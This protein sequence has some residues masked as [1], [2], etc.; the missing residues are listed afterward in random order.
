MRKLAIIVSESYNCLRGQANAE[1][2]RIKYLKQIADYQIDVFSFSVYEGWLV[3]KLRGTEYVA[4]PKEKTIDGIKIRYR[5]QS[6]S[7]I[8]YLLEVKFHLRPIVNKNWSLKF[9]DLFKDYD[10]IMAHSDDCG[11][12]ALSVHEKYGIPYCITWHGSDIHTSPFTSQYNFQ[13]T[14]KILD[15]ATKNFMVSNMLLKTA[16]RISS[17]GNKIVLYNGI[18]SDYSV[19]DE[20]K[21]IEL[22][23][24]YKAQG[25]K[26][27]AFVGNLFPVKNPMSLPEIFKCT[28]QACENVEFWIMG[29][30]KLLEPVKRKC[31]DY[32][33][34]VKC[35]G[36]V[37]SD[38]M[39]SRYNCID[40]LVLPSINEGLPLVVVEA[41]A[42]GANVV[43][44][45]AGGI[46][47][48]IGEENSFDLDD[49]HFAQKVAHRIVQMLSKTVKQN[50]KSCFSWT[51]TARN[52]NNV[53]LEIFAKYKN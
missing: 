26:I 35:L 30:G 19:F 29:T 23:K 13:K 4:T 40:V 9:T 37:P 43:G 33:L 17:V 44:S 5:W 31:S 38:E 18:N 53:Y 52:E 49:E 22:R 14:K 3:R 39:P 34:P 16:E 10:L 45:K 41:L 25:K 32:N 7:L 11:A 50:L 46:P 48:V 51:E 42:C 47:E 27:V 24:R 36:N 21:R 2:N 12:L 28:F 1:L 8:D 20:E 6:F 15:N